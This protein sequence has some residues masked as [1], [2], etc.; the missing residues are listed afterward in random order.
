MSAA[1]HAIVER[2]NRQCRCVGTDVP[3]LRSW[4][5][6]DLRTRGLAQ[7]IV[8]THP[9]LFS[10]L[11]VFV[12]HIHTAQMQAVIAAVECVV[13]LP[14]YREAVLARA[15]AI[16]HAAPAAR[17]VFLGYDFH[18]S[19]EGPKLIEIN[20]NAG[21]ALLNVEM[22]RAQQV[23]CRE[24]AEHLRV[25]PSVA[26]VEET[27][28]EM[29]K[30]EWHLARGNKPLECIAIVDE[31]PEQQY[32]YPE[33]LLFQQLF[34]TRDIH[35]V[36]AAP[37]QLRYEGGALR[38]GQQRIDM[39]YNRLTDFYLQLPAHAAI[40]Q[41]YIDN[42]S[43]VTPHPHA[44]ALYANKHNLV[45]LSDEHEL[46]ALGVDSRLREVLL[47]GVPRTRA[48][49]STR[50]ETDVEHWWRERKQWFFKPAHGFGSRGSYRG[51]KLTRK[52]FS[53][54]LQGDYVAQSCVPPSERSTRD[55]TGEH[56]L[57]FDV[58]NYVY[59]GQTQ[60]LAARLYQGQTTN[61]RTEGGGFAPVYSINAELS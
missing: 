25:R 45:L 48:V 52:V 50:E 49:S 46:T 5:D 30:R 27:F 15:P 14:A 13:A 24:V 28:F 38:F 60:L 16:A 20:T 61:F 51:D 2:L 34:E 26:E 54:I 42:A 4:L 33:L 58:R 11:P 6:R 44:H 31:T 53:E 29:F 36:I 17:G 40:A 7:P 57:K 35:A 1:E 37:E 21:G 12:A 10:E 41:A 56:T 32:L 8:E 47:Q 43:V 9:H 18:L 59:A 19:H 55:A 23:C 3:A 22:M 39:I